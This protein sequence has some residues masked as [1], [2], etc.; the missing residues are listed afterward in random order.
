MLNFPYLEFFE[1]APGG[2]AARQDSK[3]YAD[4]VRVNLPH[5]QYFCLKIWL[6]LHTPAAGRWT[7]GRQHG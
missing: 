3:E 5:I 7:H 4:R 1:P 2:N 6:L